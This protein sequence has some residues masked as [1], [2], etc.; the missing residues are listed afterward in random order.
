[1]PHGGSAPPDTTGQA[2]TGARPVPQRRRLARWRWI[3]P[4]PRRPAGPGPRRPYRAGQV[5]LVILLGAL[6][7]G[8]FATFF[9]GG[10]FGRAGLVLVAAVAV[11]GAAGCVAAARLRSGLLVGLAGVLGALVFGVCVPFAGR[12][13]DGPDVLSAFGAAARDGW[14]RM[15]TVGLP[16]EA[17]GDLLVTPVLVLWAVAFVAAVLVVRTDSVLAPLLPPVL[18][19][20]VALM[21]TAAR[22]RSL[23]ATT[24]LIIAAAGLL[25]VVRV[26]RLASAGR[27]SAVALPGVDPA[28]G[29]LD[30]PPAGGREGSGGPDADGAAGPGRA[31][32]SGRGALAGFV[33][34]E[35]RARARPLLG[36]LAFGLPVV[37]VAAI[38]GTVAAGVLPIAGGADRFDPREHRTPPVEV[39]TSLNPLVQIKAD[40]RAARAQ[41]LFTVRLAAAGKQVAT[42]RLRTLTLA[43]FD[44][45]SWRTDGR[46]VRSGRV[47]PEGHG[48]DTATGTETRMEVTVEAPGG[49][50][51]PTI[52]R[53][54]RADAASVDYA[55]Q[56]DAGVLAAQRPLRAGDRYQLTARVP[57]PTTARLR[58][59]EPATGPATERYRNLPSGLP[60]AL[61]DLAA[62]AT[63]G[64]T[65][66]YERLTAL[67]EYLRDP[68]AFTVDVDARP[69]HSYGALNRFLSPKGARADHRGY[70]EQFAT[71]FALLARVEGF[72]SRV[73][74]GYL[75]DDRFKPAPGTF[76]VTSLQSFAWPEVALDGLGWVA[77]DPTDT[78]RLGSRPP[79]DDVDLPSGGDGSSAAQ[80]QTAAAIIT[81]ELDRLA[82]LGG[83]GGGGAERTTALAVLLALLAVAVVSPL[84]I[85]GEKRRR[86]RRRRAGT[87]AARIAGA[88]L[89]VRDRLAERGVSRS[90]A[91]T[92]DEVVDRVRAARG[93]GAADRVG[94]LAPLVTAALFAVAEPED[95]Q[96]GRAWELATAAGREL[97]RTDRPVRR[98]VAAIDPRPLLPRR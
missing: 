57:A 75:L 34:R 72:P 87:T 66:P 15:L 88:W 65:T 93:A 84:A 62:T 35:G 85:V 11:A 39:T 78:R 25:A 28:A 91:F 74:V 48:P 58:A 33:G 6:T 51:L 9:A 56:P 63:S 73:A 38:L 31:G 81:P 97:R 47:L 40:H 44:G 49:V 79:A 24:G 59:A 37:A 20:V 64:A 14:A 70:V 8:A 90:R 71:A 95:A 19:F 23:L 10:E 86:R 36:R 68:A 96:A 7:A 98:L 69:G 76:T 54:V 3:V 43:D 61:G 52:G 55:F 82:E 17:E 42:R 1:M 2:E 27:V 83:A 46:F 89:E 50:F 41:T 67:A 53:P 32:R 60:T 77:F 12:L 45:A 18:G 5:A 22:G 30:S 92:T 13:A 16:A 94:E 29:E 4:S 26:A 21:F 80:A